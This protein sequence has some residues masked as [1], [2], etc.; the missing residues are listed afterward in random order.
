VS[1]EGAYWRHHRKITS[2]PFN[3]KNNRMVWLEAVRQTQSMMNGWVNESDLVSPSI[4]DIA[5]AAMRLALHVI[6]QSGFGVRLQWPHEEPDSI[7]PEGHTMSFK[8]ALGTLLENTIPIMY[9]P[10]WI[11]KNSPIKSHKV[12]YA[13]FTE[14]G[15]YMREL[16]AEKQ[17]DVKAGETGEGMDLMGTLVRGAGVKS[18]QSSNGDPEKATPS[19]SQLLTEDEILG[20]AFVFIIAGH[21]TAAN[22]IHFSIMLLA[23]HWSSQ[24]HLQDDLDAILG[25]RPPS[26]WDYETDMPKLFGS[27]CGA[28]MNEE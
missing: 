23:M 17:R 15:Q 28:V 2:P 3:E 16:Y 9:M 6:S 25:D 5:S 27:M 7:I 1:S 20:N 18:E 8:D 4:T 11:L 26:E 19:T 12:S 22:T 21:E 24:K 10:R 14:W 13:A